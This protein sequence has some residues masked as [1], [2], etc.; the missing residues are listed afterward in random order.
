[1]LIQIHAFSKFDLVYN[2]KS[3]FP[4]LNLKI[5]Q[6]VHIYIYALGIVCDSLLLNSYNN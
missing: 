6:P 3:H 1:M 5:L 2:W 4:V